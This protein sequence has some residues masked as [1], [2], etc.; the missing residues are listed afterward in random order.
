MSKKKEDN[1]EDDE[2]EDDGDV[3]YS[4]RIRQHAAASKHTGKVSHYEC[5]KFR[6]S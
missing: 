1:K 5:M 4:K 6:I 2:D 3:P